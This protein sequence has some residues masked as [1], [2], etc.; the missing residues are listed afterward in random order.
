MGLESLNF[1][2]GILKFCAEN[3]DMNEEKGRKLGS[4][5]YDKRL[6]PF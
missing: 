1:N 6:M 5:P 3:S 2:K 4:L